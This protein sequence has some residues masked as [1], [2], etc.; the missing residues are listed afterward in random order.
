MSLTGPIY[1]CPSSLSLP[2]LRQTLGSN[3]LA[4]VLD[5]SDQIGNELV[6]RSFVLHSP[7][8]SLSHFDFVCFTAGRGRGTEGR[9]L[10]HR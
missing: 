2:N 4:G 3:V 7:R 6:D 5:A 10:G 8:H 9:T 1:S